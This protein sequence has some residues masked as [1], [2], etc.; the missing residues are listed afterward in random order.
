MESGFAKVLFGVCRFF[1]TM[2]D[3]WHPGR[4]LSSAGVVMYCTLM[5]QWLKA[6][7]AE[8]STFASTYRGKLLRALVTSD[9]M[10]CFSSSS[11]PTSFGGSTL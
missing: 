7:L 11:S 3:T 10:G 9:S 4:W 2:V 8:R 1:P 5:K 6:S